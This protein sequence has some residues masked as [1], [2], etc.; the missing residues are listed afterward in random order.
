MFKLLYDPVVVIKQAK[1][2]GFPKILLTLFAA[3]LFA[4]AGLLFLGWRFMPLFIN[5]NLIVLAIIATLL[6]CIVLHLVA[7]FF[8]ALAMH[9]L[10]GTGGYYEGLAA[11]VLSMVAP[12]V[13]I[14]FAGAI[15]FL[16]YGTYV[17]LLLLAYGY[18]IGSATFF[19]AGKELFNVDYVAVLI[20]FLVTAF[21]L[22]SAISMAF[23]L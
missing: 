21:I 8:F 10:D 4:T 16:P 13:S 7:A 23:I 18:T 15:S 14:F 2:E 20:G 22:G 5:P 1:K 11:L 19:R 3:S 12:A 6:G 9:V 17:G